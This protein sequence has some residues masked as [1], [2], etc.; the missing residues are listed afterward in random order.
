MAGDGS[1]FGLPLV[2]DLS[3]KED[4]TLDLSFHLTNSDGTD[5]DIVGWT[6]V[7]SVG[8]DKD[9][10]GSGYQATYPGTGLTAGVLP[11]DFDLFDIP[12]GSYKYDLRITDTVSAD[13]PEWVI[14]EG[15]FKVTARIN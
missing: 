6:A 1:V 8:P 14:A 15:S 13:N 2:C 12:I 7:L 9:T 4:D 3:R 5:A 11:I 10:I